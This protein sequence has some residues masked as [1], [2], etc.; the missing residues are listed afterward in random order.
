ML[1]SFSR[2]FEFFA[3]TWTDTRQHT[4]LLDCLLTRNLPQCER[5]LFSLHLRLVNMLCHLDRSCFCFRRL[6][7]VT[8]QFLVAVC[9]RVA[10]CGRRG[11]LPTVV[12][13]LSEVLPWLSFFAFIFVLFFSPMFCAEDVRKRTTQFATLA[14]LEEAVYS[15]AKTVMGVAL[16]FSVAPQVLAPACGIGDREAGSSSSRSINHGTWA[17]TR[18]ASS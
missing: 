11:C 6:V 1:P 15:S 8:L 17:R 2:H 16:L 9:S 18:M 3:N 7:R 5:V 13:R 14:D 12:P 10:S 4:S